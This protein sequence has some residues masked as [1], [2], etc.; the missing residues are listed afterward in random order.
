M[1]QLWLAHLRIDSIDSL[2]K[3]MDGAKK[4]SEYMELLCVKILSYHKNGVLKAWL[5]RQEET[6]NVFAEAELKQAI[7]VLLG[8]QEKQNPLAAAKEKDLRTPT[9]R[10]HD[11]LGVLCGVP[12]AYFAADV[13]EKT[14]SEHETVKRKKLRQLK[15]E[16]WWNSYED[17]FSAVKD[18]DW[19]YVVLNQSQ[20][21][22]ALERLR[23][24]SGSVQRTLYLCDSEEMRGKWYSLN[25]LHLENVKI[26]GI[27]DPK[28]Q[29][30]R[31]SEHF[32]INAAQQRIVLQGFVLH[33][34]KRECVVSY[35]KTAVNYTQRMR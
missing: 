2:R 5:L 11:A 8:K 15:Q 27:G 6:N 4:D 30:A 22:G 16:N 7:N 21:D 33:F 10:L 14:L 35:E 28:V 17:L 3:L 1:Q 13:V 18:E 9:Q 12:A 20:L 32:T 19:A 26:C 34:H 25:L 23:E 31:M 24:N 29:Y